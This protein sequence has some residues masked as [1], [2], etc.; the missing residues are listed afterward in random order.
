MARA[1]ERLQPSGGLAGNVYR[2]CDSKRAGARR[3]CPVLL[4]ALLAD[5]RYDPDW[6]QGLLVD[7]ERGRT[8]RGLDVSPPRQRKPFN[9]RRVIPDNAS[10]L[11]HEFDG[12]GWIQ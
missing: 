8:L 1:W 6:D 10:N 4:S 9:L 12:A 7:K 5:C 3:L 11:R 2:F